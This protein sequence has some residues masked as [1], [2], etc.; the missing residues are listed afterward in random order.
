MMLP[1]YE[2]LVRLSFA[3][4]FIVHG[5]SWVVVWSAARAAVLFSGEMRP[6][7]ASRLL[8]ALRMTPS[9][10]ALFFVAGFALPSYL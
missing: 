7:S 6:R 4:F 8:L 1:Y 2:R 3:T 10:V 9:A 5:L